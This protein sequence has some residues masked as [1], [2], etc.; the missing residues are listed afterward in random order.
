MRG[1][2]LVITGVIG[3]MVVG[4]DFDCEQTRWNS[5]GECGAATIRRPEYLVSWMTPFVLAICA[6]MAF[7]LKFS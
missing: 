5:C 1:Q 2:E 7:V 4:N 6:L 3:S